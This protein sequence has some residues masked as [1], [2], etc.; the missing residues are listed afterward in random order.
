MTPSEEEV[1]AG[2]AYLK[3]KFVGWRDRPVEL[4]AESVIHEVVSMLLTRG[5]QLYAERT[6]E[7]P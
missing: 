4:P 2:V 7:A 3:Q 1:R 6:D 5:M